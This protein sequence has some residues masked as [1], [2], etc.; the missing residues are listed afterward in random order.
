MNALKK[1]HKTTELEKADILDKRKSGM[2]TK[3]IARLYDLDTSSVYSI[4]RTKNFKFSRFKLDEKTRKNMVDD[5][6]N[7]NMNC[8]ELSNKYDMTNSG[9]AYLLKKEGIKIRQIQ[10]FC[11]KKYKINESYFERIDTE[12]KAYFLGLLYA[13]GCN[14]GEG[15]R[16]SLQEPDG[17]I[18][19][20]LKQKI[21][22]NGPI[23]FCNKK[24]TA[25][26]N[27]ILLD[28]YSS[29]ISADLSN[30]GCFNKKSL[31]LKFPTNEQVPKY[32]LHHFIR[33]CFDGDGCLSIDRK[34][35]GHN[36]ISF[37]S[38][39]IF[40]PEF[41]KLLLNLGIENMYYNMR[42]VQSLKIKS[43]GKIKFLDW[44]YKDATIYLF[45]KFEKQL[46]IREYY[47]WL[48]E[49][50]VYNNKRHQGKKEGMEF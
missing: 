43:R 13:D 2:S 12:D 29:K 48:K 1:T 25:H 16:I 24:K 19:S 28:I 22:Y 34:R 40:I 3:D 5:Y 32:L 9:I 27:Q 42:N 37:V 21:D 49:Q 39:K 11:N 20:I 8:I 15:F 35:M 14:H 30:L 26:Q 4:L 45:R 18:L 10:G 50:E 46:E 47:E 6:V 41:S 17:Y 44:I 23:K 33:G 36:M 7:K 31:T 38:S